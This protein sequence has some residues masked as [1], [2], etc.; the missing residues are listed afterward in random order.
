MIPVRAP[1]PSSS[2]RRAVVASHVRSTAFPA[3]EQSAKI[4][5][6]MNA[7]DEERPAPIGSDDRTST[8][9]G[10]M[11]TPAASSASSAPA[12][13]D[14]HDSSPGGATASAANATRSPAS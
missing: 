1:V 8:V 3:R 11:R 5:P 14:L 9:A 2:A 6:T 13:Y 4:K 7:A 12:T 10:G